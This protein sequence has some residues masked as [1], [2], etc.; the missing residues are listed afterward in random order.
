MLRNLII[1]RISSSLKSKELNRHCVRKIWW[2][3]SLLSFF[4]GVHCSAKIL[5]KIFAFVFIAVTNLSSTKRGGIRGIFCRC[6]LFS[7]LTNKFFACNKGLFNFLPIFSYYN[8][9]VVDLSSSVVKVSRWT[10]SLSNLPSEYMF[11]T[12]CLLL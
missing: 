6:K 12:C 9:F 4:K 5:L 8:A 10:K 3:G 7:V 2:D 11:C 1:L